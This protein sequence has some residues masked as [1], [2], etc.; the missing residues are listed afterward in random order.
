MSTGRFGKAWSGRA[1]AGAAMVVVAVQLLPLPLAVRNLT[2]Y[3]VALAC[4]RAA[5]RP[6]IALPTRYRLVL[7][8]PF[9]VF[10]AG[11]TLDIGGDFVGHPL[12]LSGLL[13]A[14]W[15]PAYAL[16]GA[17]GLR[18]LASRRHRDGLG[19]LLDALIVSV[20]VSV[21]LLG[22]VDEGGGVQLFST[23]TFWGVYDA[24][25]VGVA[26]GLLPGLRGQP[27]AAWMLL[28]AFVANLVADVVAYELVS[29]PHAE[30]VS[31][32]LWAL[33]YV[34][35]IGT[36]RSP[37]LRPAVARIGLTRAPGPLRIALL[38]VALLA[39]TALLLMEEHEPIADIGL[40][41]VSSV[42]LTGLIMAR[43]GLLLRTVSLAARELETEVRRDPLTDLPNRRSWDFTL[44]RAIASAQPFCVAI[45]DL[46]AFK[47]YNDRL[48]HQAGDELLC[49]TAFAWSGRL[50]KGEVVAR[51]GGEE[52]ALLV[53][54][55]LDS[56]QE[57]VEDVRRAV[58][59][60][61]TCSAGLTAWAPGE[62]PD[63]LLERA[64]EALYAAKRGGRDRLVIASPPHAQAL[65]R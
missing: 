32:A 14:F 12:P 20:G 10:A 8:A 9:A 57:R 44:A 16:M 7:A 36:L 27:P 47:A 59:F 4:L 3:A 26:C 31:N 41:V 64:D 35:L 60:G 54:G 50:R 63:V 30:E 23:G 52:F 28:G 53:P 38:G 49:A 15:L 5:W 17:L 56:A 39:P 65:A 34:L 2:Y 55:G 58:P 61:A 6:A 62:T 33:F 40:V 24:V 45:L 11:E 37:S 43:L 51:W 18:A 25:L 48:G 46:D 1:A 42:L 13:S 29:V 22:W 19:P 21:L